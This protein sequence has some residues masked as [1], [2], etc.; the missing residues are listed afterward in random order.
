MSGSRDVHAIL[1]IPS[2]DLSATVITLGVEGV[3]EEGGLHISNGSSS[4]AYIILSVFDNVTV[5][6]LIWVIRLIDTLCAE[7]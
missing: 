2:L 6:E 1:T 4:A 5:K 7:N 3:E